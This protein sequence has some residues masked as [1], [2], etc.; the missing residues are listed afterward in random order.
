MQNNHICYVYIY[1]DIVVTY[2][3][4]G[5][6]NKLVHHLLVPYFFVW[7]VEWNKLIHHHPTPHN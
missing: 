4:F 1:T 6:R 5:L 3:V 2:K 7:F